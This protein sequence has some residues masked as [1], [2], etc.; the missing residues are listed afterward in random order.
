MSEKMYSEKVMEH[1]QNP[2]NM[3]KMKN[4]DVTAKIGNPACVLPE[5]K[6]HKND[7]LNEIREIDVGDEVVGHN[8]SLGET[9]K[10]VENQYSG[11]LIRLKNILGEV[12]LTPEHLVK[13]IKIPDSHCY[14]YTENKKELTDQVAW[15]HAAELNEGDLIPYPIPKEETDIKKIEID[16]S[17]RELD[18]RS[19]SFPKEIEIDEEFLR[20]A[21]YYLAVGSLR[22]EV[23]KKTFK[24]SFNYDEE[25]LVKDS[26]NIIKEKFGLKPKIREEKHRKVKLIIV[27]SSKL[28]DLFQRMFDSGASDKSIPKKYLYFPRKKQKALLEGMWKGDGYFDRE[29]PGAGYSTISEEL[30]NDL[31]ILLLRQQIIPSIYRE[32]ATKRDRVHHKVAHRINIGDVKSL[33]KLAQKLGINF[34][35]NKKAVKNAWIDDDSLYTPIDKFDTKEYSGKVNNL[36]VS[37]TKSFLTQAFPLHNCGDVM[38]IYLKVE[39]NEEGEKAIEDIK[40]KTFGCA[41]AIATSSVTTEMVKGMTLNEAEKIDNQDVAEELEGLPKIKM[42]CSNLSANGLHKALYK[43]RKKHGMEISNDLEAKYRASEKALEKTE[44]MREE[45]ED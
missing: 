45:I 33:S 34:E 10:T 22:N 44:E 12:Y 5:T 30:V 35:T 18:Y 20:L 16:L 11:K 13:A 39:E 9:Q 19:R 3:G 41:A 25:E 21:G 40:F 28:V 27:Y 7:S 17:E 24:L 38:E 23:T 2:R 32:E 36:E 31:K 29:K 1:F 15:H 26:Y 37:K 42:H 4:P 14:A 43:Y 8:G 6:I